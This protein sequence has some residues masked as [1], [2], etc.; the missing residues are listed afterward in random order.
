MGEPNKIRTESD[1]P[2]VDRGVARRQ[3]FLESARTVFMEQ[4]FEAA[5]I[6]EVVGRAGGSLATLY[7]QFGSK[8]GLFLA[9]FEDQ[10]AR[11][12]QD[13]QPKV[14]Y[15]HLPLEKGLC[16]LGEQFLRATLMPENLAFYRLVVGGAHA[17]PQLLQRYLVSG[18]ARL[19][20]ALL[21][22]LHAAR[23]SDGRKVSNPDLTA[24]FFFDLMRSYHHYRALASTE[25]KLTPEQLSAHV[26]GAVR[27]MLV[28]ALEA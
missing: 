17:Y 13:V 2:V 16:V 6:N 21:E 12:I 11:F 5:S 22:Y 27:V 25:Y 26:E 4:G 9:V 18:L 23:T 14:P 10:Y 20:D 19:R 3:A 28:G 7:S 8:E 15:S 24:H 1:N